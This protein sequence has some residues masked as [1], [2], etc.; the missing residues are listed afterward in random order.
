[1]NNRDAEGTI[2]ATNVSAG[3]WTGYF[4]FN[5]RMEGSAISDSEASN[6]SVDVNL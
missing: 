5:I 6:G 3:A 2:K 1:M 4:N